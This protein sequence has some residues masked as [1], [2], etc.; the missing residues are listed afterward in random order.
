MLRL[1]VWV[2][3]RQVSTGSNI[4]YDSTTPIIWLN[5]IPVH[6][7]FVLAHAIIDFVKLGTVSE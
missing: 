7:K 1:C 5:A 2:G 6:V 3:L 4:V